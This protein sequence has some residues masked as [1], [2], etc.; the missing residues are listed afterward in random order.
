MFL[1]R[2]P[3][4]DLGSFFG[5]IFHVPLTFKES[6]PA[7]AR[8]NCLPR[9]GRCRRHL[10]HGRSSLHFRSLAR[11]GQETQR[12][13]ATIRK[14][15]TSS[16]CLQPHRSR[17]LATSVLTASPL[18][19]RKQ[20]T[21][22]Q[23]TPGYGSHLLR[24]WHSFRPSEVYAANQYGPPTN[25]PTLYLSFTF[26]TQ[27]LVPLFAIVRVAAAGRELRVRDAA[28]KSGAARLLYGMGR[29]RR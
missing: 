8:G 10:L 27:S 4:L 20:K 6:R 12:V 1:L 23:H 25:L 15:G 29:T 24:H 26:V 21:L 18:F 5:A 2:D 13:L 11:T 14:C 19:Q 7:A 22:A 3:V 9:H 17:C 16:P 28:L